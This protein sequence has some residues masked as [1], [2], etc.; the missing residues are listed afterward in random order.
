M[1]EIIDANNCE[2]G[3]AQVQQFEYLDRCIKEALRLY[4]VVSMISRKTTEDCRLCKILFK[5]F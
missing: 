2:I 1:T 4:P 3:D 5:I